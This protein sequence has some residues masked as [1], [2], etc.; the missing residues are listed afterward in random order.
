M[1]KP[2]TA[3]IPCPNCGKSAKISELLRQ[4]PNFGK[5]LI[6]TLAC[7]NC[8]FRFNDV[9]VAEFHEPK[10][11]SVRVEKPEDLNAK[12]IRNSS[13]TIK[14]PELGIE[15]EPGPVSEGYISNIEG[16]IDRIEGATKVLVNSFP[17]DSEE[18]NEAVRAMDLISKAKIPSFPYTV[19]LYDPF[20]NSGIIAKNVREIKLS[21]D[22]VKKLKK[23]INVFELKKSEKEK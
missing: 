21:Q 16:L 8:G 7:D 23:S 1:V 20:G 13:C 11:F 18:K 12:I 17:E 22:Q 19:E 2:K 15:I 4:I 14:I 6:S 10:A 3:V 5:T 9:M